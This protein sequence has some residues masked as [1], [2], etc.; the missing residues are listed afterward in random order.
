MEW[1]TKGPYKGCYIGTCVYCGDVKVE[2]ATLGLGRDIGVTPHCQS[3]VDMHRTNRTPNS[4][5]T[6]GRY[7]REH[8]AEIASDLAAIGPELT[9]QRWGMS[10]SWLYANLRKERSAASASRRLPQWDGQWPLDV[11]VAWLNAAAALTPGGSKR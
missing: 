7:W 8:L 5:V 11:K 2:D 9:R 10:D 6:R 3:D 4:Y 1:P